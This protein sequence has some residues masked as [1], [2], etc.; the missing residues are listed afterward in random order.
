MATII[1]DQQTSQ[2]L[3]AYAIGNGS[4]A[5]FWRNADNAPSDRKVA[6][7]D[8]EILCALINTKELRSYRWFVSQCLCL[9]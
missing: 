2:K 6:K 5:V 9:S 4:L 1:H 7:E 8:A 3:S